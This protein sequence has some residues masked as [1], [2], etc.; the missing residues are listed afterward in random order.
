MIGVATF[1]DLI[2]GIIGLLNFSIIGFVIVIIVAWIPSLF[3]LMTFTLWLTIKGEITIGK[4]SLLIAPFT[5]GCVG[6]PAWTATIWPLVTKTIAVKK[7]GVVPGLENASK[8]AGGVKNKWKN[9]L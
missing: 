4:T 5:S 9:F 6:V 2:I 7:I 3:A 1:Y 8:L